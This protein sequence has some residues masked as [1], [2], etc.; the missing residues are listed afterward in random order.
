[1]H[2]ITKLKDVQLNLVRGGMGSIVPDIAAFVLSGDAMIGVLMI[3][4]RKEEEQYDEE[5]ARMSRVRRNHFSLK[6]RLQR[7]IAS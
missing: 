3:F 1:M 2:N 6:H 4:T 5:E 7:S